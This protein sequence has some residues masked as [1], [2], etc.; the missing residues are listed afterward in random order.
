MQMR[1][2]MSFFISFILLLGI[3]YIEML[4]LMCLCCT[5]L[6]V[7]FNLKTVKIIMQ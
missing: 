5:V 7:I 1:V 3:I 2:K 4:L 6:I